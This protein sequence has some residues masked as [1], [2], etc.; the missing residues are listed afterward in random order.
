MN[1]IKKVTSYILIGLVLTFTLIAILGIWDI[2]S[3]EDIIMKILKSLFVIFIAA[4]VVLFIFG[5]V[6]R[7]HSD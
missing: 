5:V 3:L 2:I 6:M 1:S 7:D 4:V